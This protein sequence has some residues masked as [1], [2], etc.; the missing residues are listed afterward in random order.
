M[1]IQQTTSGTFDI[2]RVIQRTFGVIGRN[3]VPFVLLTLLFKTVPTVA[4][5]YWRLTEQK[6]VLNV[7]NPFG[8]AFS[9]QNILIG[10]V[11]LIVG[12][13]TVFVLQAALLRGT[14]ADLNGKRASL[15]D[16]LSTG[17]RFF[18][19][20]LGLGIV[21]GI[22]V[23]FGFLLFIVP[24][25][26]MGVAWC[27]AAPAVVAEKVGVFESFTRS[28]N[29]TRGHRWAI[30]GLFVIY[31]VISW[32]IGAVGSAFMFGSLNNITQMMT[33]TLIVQAIVGTLSALIGSA[34]SAAL[35]F[36]LRTIK[37]GVG[38]DTLASVFD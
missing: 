25:I 37:E 17:F 34:G 21:M 24:A 4:I 16:M 10:V 18:F 30:F 1:S 2:G 36:E 6:A 7:N 35:Y 38:A 20:L 11:S 26:M 14:L 5:G 29:L 22:A 32:I 33:I 31:A 12:I 9:S 19:P 3:F 27:A 15:G 13:M 23:A 28:A 8:A